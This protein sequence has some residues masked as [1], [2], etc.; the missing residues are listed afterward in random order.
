MLNRMWWLTTI[1]SFTYLVLAIPS[2]DIE[3]RRIGMRLPNIL[4]FK[5]PSIIE[6]RRIGMRLPNIIY[7][8][9]EDS[10]NKQTEDW[11]Y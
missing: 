11:T 2:Q 1:L 10:T 5:S 9:N 4:H 6:K 7:L 3:K 8:R